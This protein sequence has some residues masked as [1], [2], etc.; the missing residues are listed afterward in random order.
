MNI[1]HNYNPLEV[2]RN[3]LRN[4]DL[5]VKQKKSVVVTRPIDEPEIQYVEKDVSPFIYR[6][7]NVLEKAGYMNRSSHQ[8][9]RERVMVI[10][11]VDVD[12]IR[13]SPRIRNKMKALGIDSGGRS[14][15]YMYSESAINKIRIYIRKEKS[16]GS[17]NL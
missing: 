16:N 14:T 1:N 17:N 10:L 2:A 4:T 8:S 11:C 5:I 13:L 9:L 7:E 12:Y 15:Q 6:L 3:I